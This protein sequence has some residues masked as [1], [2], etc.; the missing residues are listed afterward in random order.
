[1][2]WPTLGS[3]KAKEQNGTVSDCRWL[4]KWAGVKRRRTEHER[5]EVVL[6]FL[7]AGLESTVGVVSCQPLIHAGNECSN[8]TTFLGWV[9]VCIHTHHHK[10]LQ[11][12]ITQRHHS[13][14]SM[15]AEVT[16]IT[17][18]RMWADARSHG[19]PAEYRWRPL[20]KFHNSIPCTMPQSL[21]DG[22]CSS[23]V[24]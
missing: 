7:V 11:L 9:V 2:V 17:T 22:R 4:I 14:V 10:V 3:R 24:Q 6:Q 5:A 13:S 23:A 21:A 16:I 18:T 8:W 19:R 12:F 1:M 20:Q 15:Q